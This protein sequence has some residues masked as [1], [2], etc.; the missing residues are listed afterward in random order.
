VSEARTFI[1]LIIIIIVHYDLRN[2]AAR[3]TQTYKDEW[4]EIRNKMRDYQT[5]NIK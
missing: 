2:E 4:T 3:N 1:M 5:Q